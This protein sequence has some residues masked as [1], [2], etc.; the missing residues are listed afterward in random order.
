MARRELHRTMAYLLI[1][2]PRRARVIHIVRDPR[3]FVVS[4]DVNLANR[5]MSHEQSTQ[6]WNKYH[7]YIMERVA[8]F[9]GVEYLRVRYEDLCA[10]PRATMERAFRF[11]D[12]E[13]QD[14]VV[15]PRQPHHIIGNRMMLEFDGTV[16]LDTRWRERLSAV[17]QQAILEKTAPLAGRFGYAAK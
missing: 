12:V 4:C 1:V 2:K 14:V 7:A 6:V 13:P 11:L 16:T 17:Q 3:G 5:G 8:T 9:P 15:A 10:D